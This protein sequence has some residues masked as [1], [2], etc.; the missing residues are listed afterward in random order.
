LL[1]DTEISIKDVLGNDQVLSEYISKA[2]L[3][4]PKSHELCLHHYPEARRMAQIGG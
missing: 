4:K 3:L 2:V 1:I